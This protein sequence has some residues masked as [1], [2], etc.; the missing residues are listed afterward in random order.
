[1]SWIIK[2]GAQEATLLCFCHVCICLC[3]HL[4]FSNVSKMAPG[5]F[6]YVPEWCLCTSMSLCVDA[7]VLIEKLPP[8]LQHACLLQESLFHIFQAIRWLRE[9]ISI[10]MRHDLEQKKNTWNTLLSISLFRDTFCLAYY[11]NAVSVK[12]P[13]IQFTTESQFFSLLSEFNLCFKLSGVIFHIL[14]IT[15]HLFII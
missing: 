6:G 2:R 12:S 11:G 1:M 14:K 7:H 3:V 5:V 10:V 9:Q 4:Q 8:H 15:Q 13:T